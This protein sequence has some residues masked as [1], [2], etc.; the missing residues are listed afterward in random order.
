MY[1]VVLPCM[2]ESPVLFYLG[3]SIHS[4]TEN[5]TFKDCPPAGE[6]PSAALLEAWGLG[7]QHYNSQGASQV[8]SARIERPDEGHKVVLSVLQVT[9]LKFCHISRARRS[10]PE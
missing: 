9:D 3:G 5:G 7:K 6:G 10:Q 1:L 8:I 4:S 2:V